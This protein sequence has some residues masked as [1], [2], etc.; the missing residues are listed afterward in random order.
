MVA[1]MTAWFVGAQFG[2]VAFNWTFYYLLGLAVTPVGI[3]QAR[4]RAY[5]KAKALA[6]R[7]FVAA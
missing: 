1:C 2:S 3:I 4:R 5:A 6:G 7:E